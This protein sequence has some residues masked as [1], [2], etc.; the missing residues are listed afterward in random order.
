M[1]RTDA[2][3]QLKS[4]RQ[5]AIS[6]ACPRSRLAIQEYA[7][8]ATVADDVTA[9]TIAIKALEAKESARPHVSWVD[10]ALLLI[11]L[12]AIVAGLATRLP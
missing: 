3:R 10:L 9:L 6:R 1:T 11:S 7:D 8:T 4:L 12:T 2:I 5:E